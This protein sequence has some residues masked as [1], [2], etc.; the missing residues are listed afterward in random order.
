[1]KLYANKKEYFKRFISSRSGKVFVNGNRI[2]ILEIN[3]D[4]QEIIIPKSLLKEKNDCSNITE[5]VYLNYVSDFRIRAFTDFHRINKY[6]ITNS[7]NEAEL[8]ISL[9]TKKAISDEE[10]LDNI[11]T[12]I[13]EH[14]KVLF[15]YLDKCSFNLAMQYLIAFGD[16]MY[17][18]AYKR[19][20]VFF[21]RYKDMI[22]RIVKNEYK[23]PNSNIV[24][25]K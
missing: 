12:A 2:G 25:L 16:D 24:K 19:V 13:L 18:W 8:V 17:Y 9:I 22:E 14:K 20:D 10:F 4:N 7:L 6:N 23:V 3:G 11:K 15:I 21:D 1:M 5:K